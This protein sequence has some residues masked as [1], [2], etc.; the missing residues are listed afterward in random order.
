[1]AQ[2]FL[3]SLLHNIGELY[4]NLLPIPC[5]LCGQTDPHRP[6]CAGCISDL[7]LLGNVCQFCALP[8][9]TGTICGQCL[10]HRPIQQR[11]LSLFAYAHP[12]DR[13]VAAFKY[14]QQLGFTK[15]FAEQFLSHVDLTEP[16][17]DCLLPIPLHPKRLRQR[18][19]NQSLLFAKA[20]AKQLDISVAPKLLTRVND[21]PPQ[22]QLSFQQRRK[23]IRGAFA[24][25][26]TELPHHVAI[27]DDV[28]TSGSTVSEAATVLRRQ[29]VEIIEVW[30][31]ARAIRSR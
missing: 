7:P 12:V 19:Y 4:S 24:C 8:I 5:L 22:T 17:P 11:S 28:M 30:T 10:S 9:D 25:Q 29:G 20:L 15:L 31:I 23:N 27:V 16:L 6:L 21:T 14:Q 2:E 3:S 1:M 26:Q 13:C 18:G